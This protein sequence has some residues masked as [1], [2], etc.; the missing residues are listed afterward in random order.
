M[1]WILPLS[2]LLF[3]FSNCKVSPEKVNTYSKGMIRFGSGGGFAGAYNEFVLLNNGQLFEIPK[4]D[5]KPVEIKKV[6]TQLTT[7]IFKSFSL[8]GLDTMKYNKPDN[9]Y[10]FLKY[11]KGKQANDIV[12]GGIPSTNLQSAASIYKILILQTKNPTK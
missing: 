1:K 11:K 10:Y 5:G 4:K 6:S 9:L 3:S 8:F 12:W 7:Q 2:L